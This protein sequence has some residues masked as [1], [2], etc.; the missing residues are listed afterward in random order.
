MTVKYKDYYEMLGVDR[1]TSPEKIHK[2][3]RKLAR[4][5]HP[6]VNKSKGAEERFKELGEAYEVLKDDEKRK[7]YDRLGADWKAGQN[8][9]PPP[10]WDDT[11]IRFEGAEGLNGFSD[12]FQSIFG[13]RTVFSSLDVV[14]KKVLECAYCERSVGI[15]ASPLVGV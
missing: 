7:L 12:F 8:F 3:Y 6:D 14:T 4:K 2:Q 1:N 9:K 15:K 13:E 5:Y 10:G 11:N